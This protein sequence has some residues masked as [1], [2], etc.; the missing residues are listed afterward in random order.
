M[1]SIRIRRRDLFRHTLITFP[2]RKLCMMS[3]AAGAAVATVVWWLW[4]QHF[5]E[6]ELNKDYG[7]KLRYFREVFAK[8]V[9][10]SD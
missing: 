8:F 6:Q 9:F 4:Q 3:A 7:N 1:K 5:D 10:R 2:I